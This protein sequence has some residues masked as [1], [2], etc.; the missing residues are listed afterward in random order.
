MTVSTS[1]QCTIA[2]GPAVTSAT[3]TAAEFAA[4]SYQN[5]SQIQDLGEFGDASND[6]SAA[7]LTDGRTLHQ[8]GVFDAGTMTVVMS[9][10]RTDAGQSALAAASADTTSANYAFRITLNDGVDPTTVYFRGQVMRYRLAPGGSDNVIQA[11]AEIGINSVLVVAD[12]G[13]E[14]SIG[15]DATVYTADITSLTADYFG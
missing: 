3:D 15:A 14:E 9:Y 8:K 4:L 2:I 11:I 12:S 5:I 6:V 10:D 13:E 1:S 7:H